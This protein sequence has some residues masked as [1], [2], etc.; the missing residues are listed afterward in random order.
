[1]DGKDEQ[2]LQ[3]TLDGGEVGHW[4]LVAERARLERERRRREAE[5]RASE[6]PVEGR[7]T[8]GPQDEPLPFDSVQ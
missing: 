6:S 5:E 3:L 4:Q 2:P 8:P 7:P 1:M